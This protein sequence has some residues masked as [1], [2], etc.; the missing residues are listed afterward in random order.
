MSYDSARDFFSDIK[1]LYL[2]AI[3]LIEMISYEVGTIKGKMRKGGGKE[4]RERGGHGNVQKLKKGLY[5][6]LV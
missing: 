3:S 6:S 2:I 5:I 4:E 1:K